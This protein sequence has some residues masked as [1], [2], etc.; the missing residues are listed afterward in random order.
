MFAQTFNSIHHYNFQTEDVFPLLCPVREKDWIE[1]WNYEMIYSRSGLVEKNC[2][3]STPFAQG[4]ETIWQ[5]TEY[6]PDLN[7]IEFTR[8][9]QGL[10]TV[11][12]SIQL[13]ESSSGCTG[14]ITYRYTA[15]SKLG[16]TMI[17]SMVAQHFHDDMRYWERGLNH[18]LE[19]GKMLSKELVLG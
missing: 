4:I 9:T 16:K 8:V 12:I 3:F 13:N 1:G 15:L 6:E 5:V 2:V 14:E 7:W 19:T 10:F 18:Y 11:R 17:E